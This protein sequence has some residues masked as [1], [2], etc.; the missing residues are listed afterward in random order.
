MRFSLSL[1]KIVALLK[2]YEKLLLAKPRVQQEFKD[3]F[4]QRMLISPVR[5]LGGDP[6]QLESKMFGCE[7][8]SL[9]FL[10]TKSYDYLIKVKEYWHSQELTLHILISVFIGESV[11]MCR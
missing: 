1:T 7:T 10:G 9:E 3:K 5:V 6:T 8:L 11:I 4:D 2:A